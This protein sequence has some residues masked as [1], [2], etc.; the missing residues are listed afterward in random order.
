MRRDAAHD[1]ASVNLAL[2]ASC[3]SEARE[4]ER[5]C[6]VRRG[7]EAASSNVNVPGRPETDKLGEAGF[8]PQASCTVGPGTYDASRVIRAVGVQL[9]VACFHWMRVQLRPNSSY[10]CTAWRRLL[11]WGHN[12]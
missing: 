7:D 2:F 3:A 5:A 12:E 6:A 4:T 11:V 8:T 9:Y 10:V 1:A